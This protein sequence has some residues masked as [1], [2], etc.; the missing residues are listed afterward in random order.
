M[1]HG[2]GGGEREREREREREE[3]NE[4]QDID[5]TPTATKCLFVFLS[6]CRFKSVVDNRL[7]SKHLIISN[8]IIFI[9]CHLCEIES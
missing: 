3:E 6:V 2:G 1:L 5:N 9:A 4:I 7:I 8:E